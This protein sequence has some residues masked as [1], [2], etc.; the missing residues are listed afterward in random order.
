MDCTAPADHLLVDWED[1]EQLV[2]LAKQGHSEATRRLITR[3]HHFVR[4]KAI[5]YFIA[6]GDS[7]DLI[8]EGYIGLFKAIR[9]YQS[10][11]AASFR[12]FAE[13]CVTRQIITAIKTASPEALPL[14]T[15]MSFSYSPAGLEHEGWTLADLLRRQSAD[16]VAQVIARGVEQP[17]RLPH[18]P[19]EPSGVTGAAALLG[20][21]SYEAIAA[22]RA[23]YQDR[24]Q[25]SAAHQRKVTM[26]WRAA[27]SH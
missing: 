19:V 22:H 12:S 11:R 2:Q 13:L 26:P 17:H 15:Y 7:D 18:H 8:Q 14:N 21:Q 27:E 20:G 24:G 1:E 23:R 5:S 10:H 9:D 16:P 4:M 3:Y 25:R 6:G